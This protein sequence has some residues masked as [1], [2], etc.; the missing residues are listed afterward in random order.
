[1]TDARKHTSLKC[2][3]VWKLHQITINISYKCCRKIVF[4]ISSVRTVRFAFYH[5][6]LHGNAV[7]ANP[8]SPAAMF[9]ALPAA[10][11]PKTSNN[12]LPTIWCI[13]PHAVSQST[14]QWQS[15]MAEVIILIDINFKTQHF[16]I[17]VSGT[18]QRRN[19]VLLFF[20]PGIFFRVFLLITVSLS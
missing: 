2:R 16:P 20:S 14:L 19:A 12:R 6:I 3:I 17:N 13:F 18:C 15:G 8:L 11:L 1:M 4:R 5:F 10:F 9:E 7:D